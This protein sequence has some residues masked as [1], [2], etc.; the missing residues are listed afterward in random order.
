M[1]IE[2]DNA[3][4]TLQTLFSHGKHSINVFFVI[5]MTWITKIHMAFLL[6]LGL[7]LCKN[8]C[9]FFPNEFS[10]VLFLLQ[11]RYKFNNSLHSKSIYADR[12][13]VVIVLLSPYVFEH[14]NF[15]IGL[16]PHNIPVSTRGQLSSFYKLGNGIIELVICPIVEWRPPDF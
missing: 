9:T 16:D 1:K 11:K 12:I 6:I 10:N 7:T 8:K 13:I 5:S 15:Q 4:K 14:F 3:H 2:G